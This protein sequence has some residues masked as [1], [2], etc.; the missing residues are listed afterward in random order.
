ML[1]EEQKETIYFYA[2]NDYLLVNGLLWNEKKV[3]L[4]D[5]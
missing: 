5:T 3:K 1:T 4:I 2:A